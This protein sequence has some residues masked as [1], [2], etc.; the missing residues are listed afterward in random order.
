MRKNGSRLISVKQY[1]T[2]D[3]FLFAVILIVS[4]VLG[5][6]ATVWFSSSAYFVLS[7]TVPISALV[8]AR[9]GWWG[10]F[11]P[12]IGGL[13]G[14]ILSKASINYYVSYCVGGMALGLM[15]LPAKLIG[16]D[17]IRSKWYYTALFAIGA[18]VSV[19][20]GRSL[21]W[22]AAFAV[23]PVKGSTLTA[24]FTGFGLDVLSLVIGVIVL[25]LMRRLDGMF[26]DQKSYLKRID[27]ERR[28][29]MK[30]DEY[31]EPGELDEE[32]LSVLHRDND[33]Y[34]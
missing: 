18:W 1:K 5:H 12:L 32:A 30:Y 10:V 24:G 3:L 13:T 20:L 11:Y 4:E 27:K 22:M 29:R 2:T 26:E 6:Y 33:L 23:K 14:C 31:A 17:K 19:Y 9:W 15:L 16:I 7:L 21:M 34:D 8:I 28:D 25:L